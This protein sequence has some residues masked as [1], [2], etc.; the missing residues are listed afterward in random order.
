MEKTMENLTDAVNDTNIAFARFSEASGVRRYYTLESK[1]G[2][3]WSPCA[4][5]PMW[6]HRDIDTRRASGERLRVRLH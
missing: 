6:W 2:G 4:G 3:E 1:R 5:G